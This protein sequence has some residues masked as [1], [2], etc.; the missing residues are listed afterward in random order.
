MRS[1]LQIFLRELSTFISIEGLSG[2]P[3]LYQHDI[4]VNFQTKAYTASCDLCPLYFFSAKNLFTCDD[5]IYM[6]I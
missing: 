6:E 4:R 1:H 3:K 2:R 5:D